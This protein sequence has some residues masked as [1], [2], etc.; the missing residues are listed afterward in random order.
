MNFNANLWRVI[1]LAAG[2]TLTS[3]SMSLAG[4]FDKVICSGSPGSA[5]NQITGT[6][7]VWPSD[8]GLVVEVTNGTT[9]FTITAVK[10]MVGGTSVDGTNFTKTFDS[11]LDE[12]IRPLT[13]Q[14]AWV[15]DIVEP[16]NVRLRLVV[17]GCKD[18]IF[19]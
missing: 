1:F 16:R 6:Q 11:S 13:K 2:C 15:E 17:S 10:I 12:P 14:W 4:W 7:A 19:E 8:G 18:Y 5:A 9:D 3:P